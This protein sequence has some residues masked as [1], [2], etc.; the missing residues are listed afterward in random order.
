VFV[1]LGGEK[2]I[3]KLEELLRVD[4]MFVAADGLRKL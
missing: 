1:F 2:D 4:K 3:A